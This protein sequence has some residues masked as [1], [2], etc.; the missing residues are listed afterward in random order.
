MRRWVADFLYHHLSGK[1]RQLQLAR[2]FLIVWTGI[3]LVLVI[4]LWHQI[5]G[6]TNHQ[7]TVKLGG[8][9]VEGLVGQVK[10]INPIFPDNTATSDVV[11][12][13]FTGLTRYRPDGRLE[14]DLATSWRVSDDGRM[15]TFNLRKNVHW[16]DGANFTAHDVA[17]TIGAIQNPDSRSPLANS[18]QA[19]KV[20]EKG[21]DTVVF[22]LPSPDPSF[23]Y[24]TTVGLLPSHLLESV[25][26]ATL[27]IADFNQ[28]PVGTGPFK[29]AA[30]LPQD[31]MIE[32][33]A[34][35]NYYEGAPYLSGVAF[36]LYGQA[37][38]A[39]DAYA[40]HQILGLSLP[41]SLLPKAKKL[42][43]IKVNAAPTFS[44]TYLFF[45]DTQSAL[46]D[47]NVRSA[48]SLATSRGEI[49]KQVLDG[50]GESA[51]LP[52]LP[53]QLGYD[54]KYSQFPFNPIRAGKLLDDAGWK[55]NHDGLRYKDNQPLKL[56]L[57]TRQ[58]GDYPA[59]ASLV[60]TQW[61]RVGVY[62]NVKLVDD[63]ALQQS[64]IKP[65]HFDVLLFGL[66]LGVD[67]DVY[68]YWHSSQV[69]DPGLNV[70]QYK[71][72]AADKALASARVISDP[73][74]R[75][76]K[77]GAFLAAWSA[78]KPAIG[79]YNPDYL[80]AVSDKLHGVQI[81][82]LVQPSDRYYGISRWHF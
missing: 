70:S 24:S 20:E 61:Q 77:Y 11:H 67:P 41:P 4:G 75:S 36:H 51:P 56:T 58:T 54:A 37:S 62:L 15:Y 66:S 57:V 2:R 19:V 79:L 34:N 7:A 47:V 27:R 35:A 50:Q 3:I 14:S 53:G 49:L 48:L 81:D 65:R 32:L 16:Q 80:Y 1:W 31:N 8:Q 42:P 74:T 5:G 69:D 13:V 22:T 82:K 59:V 39:L 45:R 73:A 6:Y 17:F 23:V 78:D 12:L 71:S 40:K 33:A 64:Y 63:R 72:E 9:Y 29:L 44:Q 10:N 28:K 52:L 18:W 76:V 21:A 55:M 30:Y 38:D 68:P 43:D 26:P 60:Q 25:R 46:S